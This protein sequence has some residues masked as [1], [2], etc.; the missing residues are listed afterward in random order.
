MRID[1][2]SSAQFQDYARL[3]DEFGIEPFEPLVAKLPHPARIFRRGVVFGHRGFQRVLDAIEHNE[4]FSVMTGFVP[5]GPMHIGHKM[6]ID[7]VNYFTSLGADAYIGV[8]DIEALGARHISTN[9]ADEI[10]LEHY[11]TNYI[12]LG[13]DAKK[14]QIYFQSKRKPVM[15]LAYV[16]AHETNWNEMRAI[17]GFEDSTNM[18]KVFSPIV[19]VADILHPQLERYGGPKPVVVPVGVDQDPH[20]RLT[21]GIAFAQRYYNVMVAKDGRPGVFVKADHSIEELLNEAENVARGMGF[22]KL[23]KIPAYK[24]LYLDD[25]KPDDLPK[26]DEKLIPIEVK[27]GGYGFIPPAS[28]YHRFMT[29]LTGEKMSSSKPETAI[30]LTD[31]PKDAEKKVRSSKTG[32]AVSVEEQRKTGG[33]PEACSVYELFVYH[34]IDSDEELAEI[35]NKCTGGKMLCGE[36]KQFAASLV[37]KFLE[38]FAHKREE[39]KKRIDE[40]VRY[41]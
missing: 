17:Y 29:G 6:V 15:D 35:Y 24:A 22:K 12:A 4:H 14:C 30:Y 23:K 9:R 40:F 11:I 34:F 1:P 2:W 13:L 20:I 26:L 37:G 36:C 28:T 39:A 38:D 27:Y 32:G 31:T 8:A 3:R 33:K 10:A 5:S 18:C 41:D 16:S 25:A 21:R 7:Q 19:Q